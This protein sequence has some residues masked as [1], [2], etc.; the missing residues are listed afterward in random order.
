[1]F[2]QLQPWLH[3][4]QHQTVTLMMICSIRHTVTANFYKTASSL[5]VTAAQRLI[6]KCR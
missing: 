3:Y 6:I 5:Y 1:M 4:I 2:M